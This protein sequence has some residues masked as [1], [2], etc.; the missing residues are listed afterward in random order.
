[1]HHGFIDSHSHLESPLHRLPALARVLAAFALVLTAI[2]SPMTNPF[3]CGAFL[4]AAF[5]LVLISRIPALHIAKRL[6]AISPFIFLAAV[7]LPFVKTGTVIGSVSV[8]GRELNVTSSGLA[9]FWNIIVRALFSTTVMIIL[10]SSTPLG[11]LLSALEKLK[12][13]K[14]FIMIISFMYRYTFVISGELMK[15]RMAKVSRSFGGS[16]WMHTKTLANIVG[17]L[18]LRSYERGEDVYLAMCARGF[19]GK[20]RTLHD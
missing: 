10:A 18:F 4:L 14:L 15:M 5:A 9:A 2:A 13:P 3:I 17:T 7:S 8:F 16:R 20:I 19:D 1:M 11:E 12:V 6:A